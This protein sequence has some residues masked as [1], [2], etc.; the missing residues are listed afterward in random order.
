MKEI[1]AQLGKIW[2][3]MRPVQKMVVVGCVCV[4]VMIFGALRVWAGKGSSE[5]VDV[6]DELFE[7]VAEL[8]G[9]KGFELFDTNTWI[10]GEKELQVL[11]MRALKGQLEKDLAT[12][13]QVKSANVILD[14]A[15]ARG[16]GNAKYKTKA[17]VILAL[18][19]TLTTSQ[20]RAITYHLAGAVR[21]L[22]PNMIAISDTT[23]KLYK[24][25]DPEGKEEGFLDN[26]ALAFEEHIEGKM[27][28]LLTPLVG[29]E[30]FLTSVQAT[31][32]AGEPKRVSV[33]AT[34]EYAYASL[35]EEVEQQLRVLA[36]GYEVPFELAL[37]ALPFRV[38]EVV[39]EKAKPSIKLISV[40]LTLVCIVAILAA[41][42][43]FVKR[44][45]HR[46]Q[47][48]GLVDVMTRVNINKLAESVEGEDPQV[49]AIML[50]YLEPARAEQMLA[51][52]SEAMQEDVLAHLSE[53]EGEL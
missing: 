34:L 9:G 31:V 23:G 5:S 29:E 30:N 40:V 1:A 17:S 37:N 35:L 51:A 4:V 16:F 41:L 45:S 21:G 44:R 7:Q 12:F 49:V 39:V 24:A 3:Q 28:A 48:E 47:E 53:I 43:P 13:D 6:T 18:A 19:G 15:S 33:I 27:R 14:M 26:S 46:K 52:F 38:Q 22:E 25:I 2:K 11:E 42:Y 50:S 8:E 36:A 32:E 10:K 20:Q